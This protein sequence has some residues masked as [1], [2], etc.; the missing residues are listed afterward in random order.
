[1]NSRRVIIALLSTALAACAD[2]SGIAP[3][4][5]RL[6][7]NTLDP[8]AVLKARADAAWPAEAWWQAYGDP[9]LNELVAQAIAGNPGL[10]SARARVG[11][12][13][14]LAAIARA[15]PLPR[16]DRAVE[17][18]RT[19]Q[20]HGAF[21]VDLPEAYTYWENTALLKISYDLDLWGKD[22]AAMEGALD[23]LH[24]AEVEA[25]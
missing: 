12:A 11:Q 16:V 6:D 23:S 22:R 3:Q 10:R 20:T 4:S 5:Q 18:D 14:G 1:M 13:T 9:Q 7:A 19:Y 15:G 25:R 24:A 2:L 17:L 21:P 8:G